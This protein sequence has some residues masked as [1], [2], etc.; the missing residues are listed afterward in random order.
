MAINDNVK[1]LTDE[2]GCIKDG[3]LASYVRCSMENKNLLQ[4]KYDIYVGTGNYIT[5]T[6]NESVSRE[7]EGMNIIN[8]VNAAATQLPDSATIKKYNPVKYARWG[9]ETADGNFDPTKTGAAELRIE[10]GGYSEVRIL[11]HSDD[12]YNKTAIT[13]Y[14]FWGTSDVTTATLRVDK[15]ETNVIQ[16]A[17]GYDGAAEGGQISFGGGSISL[18]T[19]PPIGSQRGSMIIQFDR[20]TSTVPYI[21]QIGLD[22]SPVNQIYAND[23]RCTDIYSS[24]DNGVVAKRITAGTITSSGEIT[25]GTI[26]SSGEITAGTITSSGEITAQSFNATSDARLKTN[27]KP[28]IY[29]DS[30]LDIPVREY[31]WKESSKHAIGFIAQE[32]KE[33]YPEL[34]DENEDGILSI[35]ETKLV[36]LLIEEVKKLKKEVEDLKKGG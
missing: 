12:L 19:K 6:S 20:I 3:Q 26:T 23:I 2:H 16:Q 5:D 15:I 11:G 31:D 9:A 17:D 8:A 32:L 36:Y 21:G 7:T 35:K 14:S 33:V 25:A 13:K 34:V 28:L 18:T 4:N 10:N 29:H 1:A 24:G 27:I 30:I 22:T